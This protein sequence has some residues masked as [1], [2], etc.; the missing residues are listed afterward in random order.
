VGLPH[1]SKVLELLPTCR[2]RAM[3]L[4]KYCSKKVCCVGGGGARFISGFEV[5][6][7]VEQCDGEG[8]VYWGFHIRL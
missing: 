3:Y 1:M 2:H 4:K 8:W 6:R 7:G 5:P